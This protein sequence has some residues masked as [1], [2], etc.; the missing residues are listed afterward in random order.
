[1][2]RMHIDCGK[3]G[4]GSMLNG[5]AYQEC[6]REL[7]TQRAYDFYRTRYLLVWTVG[8]AIFFT[9][10]GMLVW[11]IVSS[12]EPYRAAILYIV[13]AACFVFFILMRLGPAQ[14]RT[15]AGSG[16]LFG[17]AGSPNSFAPSS[18]EAAREAALALR[19]REERADVVGGAWSNVLRY[20]SA[21][22]TRIYTR[23]MVGR[24]REAGK[25]VWFAGTELMDVQK[26]L[27]KEGKQIVNMPSYG[28]VTIGAW[29]ATQGHGM[30]GASTPYGRVPVKAR[31]LDLLTGI[32]TDDGPQAL[33]EKFGLDRKASS[34]YLILW[35]SLDDSPALGPNTTLIRSHRLLTT[36]ADA[37]W[38]LSK[39]ARM[40]V[41]F[42]GNT[43]ALAARW[44]PAKGVKVNKG[45]VLFDTWMTTF[46][47]T[48][49]GGLLGDPSAAQK[50]E[51]VQK[52]VMLFHT[53][54][55]PSFIYLYLLFG[56]VNF[57]AYTTDIPITPTTL[58][59]LTQTLQSVHAAHGGRSEIRVQGKLLYVDGFAWSRAG[60]RATFAAM[61]AVGVKRCALHPGK[62]AV[63]V[64]DVTCSGLD[65][66]APREIK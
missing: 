53:Y 56:V 36:A 28:G 41:V 17:I 33:L 48:G 15:R 58:L 34:Q 26:E 6:P 46:A 4:K 62:Y 27:A 21:Q 20:E 39:D 24:N 64:E 14:L 57:E 44:L 18:M 29:I 5:V 19:R 9:S 8:F 22:A 16:L 51:T 59:S 3:G 31:V 25:H 10:I 45:G 40:C 63:L 52:A 11:A 61:A 12:S 50:T 32:E 1:M 37:E 43:K 7:K 66:V 23:R 2:L 35:V 54:L 30:T 38:L 55:Y 49:W 60:Q 47:V 65:L 13:A 42:V